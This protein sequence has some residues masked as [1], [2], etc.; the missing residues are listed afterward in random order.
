MKNQRPISV[1]IADDHPVVLKG[2]VSLLHSCPDFTVVA[3]YRDGSAA[4][5]AIQQLAPDIAVLDMAM[6]GLSGLEVLSGGFTSKTNIV[7]LTAAA[8]DKEIVTAVARGAKGVLHKEV[9]PDE[10][11]QCIREVAHGRQWF[12]E[13]ATE[14]ISNYR[15][16]AATLKHVVDQLTNREQDVMRLVSTGLSNKEIARKLKI[17]EGT[18][19]LHLH[20]IYRKVGVRN[21]TELT[22]LMV[23]DR[24]VVR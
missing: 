21:R 2:L 10:L 3:E 6:P 12:S 11:V 7:F 22:V 1:L 9:A 18:I 4:L 15:A 5:E 24:D 14:L 23:V 16:R 17:S 13:A 8:T 20:N 19:K